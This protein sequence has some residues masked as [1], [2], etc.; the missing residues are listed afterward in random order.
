M[1]MI[2]RINSEQRGYEVGENQFTDLTWEE[3]QE[4][5]L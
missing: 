4:K 1:R 2:E 3:F 5:F